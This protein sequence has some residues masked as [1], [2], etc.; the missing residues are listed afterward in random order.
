S[1][2]AAMMHFDTWLTDHGWVQRDLS[3]EADPIALETRYLSHGKRFRI[4]TR[5][6][7]EQGLES[8]LVVSID[9]IGKAYRV[10]L[11]T[12]RPSQLRQLGQAFNA[13]P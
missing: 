6:N 11:T 13:R 3:H 5:P 1:P 10:S 2:I 7:D 4:Y 8:R 9:S 12:S